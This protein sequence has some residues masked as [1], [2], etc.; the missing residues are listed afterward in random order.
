MSESFAARLPGV[1]SPDLR[2][3]LHAARRDFAAF[4]SD[5]AV[6]RVERLEFAIADMLR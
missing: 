6:L 1:L 3:A 5:I 4:S 2:W